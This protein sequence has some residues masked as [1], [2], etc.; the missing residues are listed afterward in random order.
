MQH[1]KPRTLVIRD[2]EKLRA[3]RTPLR[4]ELLQSLI[5]MEEATV[6]ELAQ[7]VGRA[8]AAIY[9][10][11]HELEKAGLVRR[12]EARRTGSRMGTAYRPVAE[13]I[14]IDRRVRSQA[15]VGALAGLHRAA[16]SKAE[17][18]ITAA[19][20]RESAAEPRDESVAFLR[21]T[22]RLS[23]KDAREARRRLKELARFMSEHSRRE[24][25]ELL[26]LTAALVK[27]A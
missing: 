13:R 7:S 18:E 17:R 5:G 9:Y 1:N 21:L 10:H 14:V 3:L 16:L 11:V 23:R 26:S 22:T 12:S 8:P 4:Q 27:S 15:F 6:K 25:G 20:A 2:A 19:L 24:G